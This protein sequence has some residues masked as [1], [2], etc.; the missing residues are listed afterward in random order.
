M[1][2]TDPLELARA[3][4]DALEDRKAEDIVLM[5][6]RDQNVFTD[7]FI[8]C[9]GTSERQLRAL[10][11]AVDETAKK[12]FR[13]KSPRVEGHAEGGWVLVDFGTLIVHCFS[14]AQRKRYKLEELWHEGKVML[15]IQ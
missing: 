3:V 1:T 10:A 12:K 2:D 7:F 6:L 15:R 4:V 11:E 5:D 14:E 13:M 8:I 9:S